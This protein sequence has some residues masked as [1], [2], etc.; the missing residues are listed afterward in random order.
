MGGQ[1]GIRSRG[2]DRLITGVLL[3]QSHTIKRGPRVEATS[4]AIR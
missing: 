4:V 3:P 1:G 2:V